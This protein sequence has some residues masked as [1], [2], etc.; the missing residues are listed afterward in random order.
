MTDAP[1]VPPHPVPTPVPVGAPEAGGP[2]IVD[3]RVGCVA[4]YRGPQLNCLDGLGE[5]LPWYRQ[6]LK[7][8]GAWFVPDDYIG[9]AH[10]ACEA[11]NREHA[12]T[13]AALLAELAATAGEEI[14]GLLDNFAAHERYCLG[15]EDDELEQASAKCEAA[16]N[17][18]KARF[19][20]LAAQRDEAQREAILLVCKDLSEIAGIEWN[21]PEVNLRDLV[22]H[23]Q[24][25]ADAAGFARGLEAARGKWDEWLARITIEEVIAFDAARHD[26]HEPSLNLE[27][28]REHSAEMIAAFRAAI[29]GITPDGAGKGEG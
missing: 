3:L 24:Q 2:Y 29:R 7:A 15:C 17:A 12:A 4:V 21:P 9:E 13:R 23:I 5:S 25:L 16:K 18:I 28:Y 20:A 27:Y 26:P 1:A 14:A 10:R 6:G 22:A 8:G 19:A 11:L